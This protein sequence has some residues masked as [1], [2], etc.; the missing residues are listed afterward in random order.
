MA[1]A[2]REREARIIL[3]QSEQAVAELFVQASQTY[4]NN[5]TAMHLRGMNMLYETMKGGLASVIIVPSTAV[6]SMNLGALGGLVAGAQSMAAASGQI[7]P[8]RPPTGSP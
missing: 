5:P 8:Q 6:D 3:G 1:Q 7:P 2:E 4:A